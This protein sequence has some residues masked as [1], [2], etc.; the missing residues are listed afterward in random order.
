M[1]TIWSFA[2]FFVGNLPKWSEVFSWPFAPQ[3]AETTTDEIIFKAWKFMS[4]FGWPTNQFVTLWKLRCDDV[5]RHIIFDIN[6]KSLQ[7][8]T[9]PLVHI[10][11]KWRK[12]NDFTHTKRCPLS[13]VE[14][15]WLD[16]TDDRTESA[17]GGIGGGAVFGTQDMIMVWWSNTCWDRETDRKRWKRSR[18]SEKQQS[19]WER[20]R[21]V[22]LDRL[23]IKPLQI[24]HE[25]LIHLSPLLR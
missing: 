10:Y 21:P 22:C 12:V 14:L 4:G 8:R 19:I 16:K 11:R 23:F 2:Y 9:F 3:C 15:M 25:H 18:A 24:H 13:D 6:F 20:K 7:N 1:N 17:R 5:K